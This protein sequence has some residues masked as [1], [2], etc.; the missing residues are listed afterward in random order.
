MNLGQTDPNTQVILQ[1]LIGLVV[2]I[3]LVFIFLKFNASKKNR[4][5]DAKALVTLQEQNHLLSNQIRQRILNNLNTLSDIIGLQPVS[6][7]T[8]HD[9]LSLE[10]RNRTKCLAMIGE[11][12]HLDTKSQGIRMAEFVHQLS[13]HLVQ[14]YSRE[15]VVHI[16]VDTQPIILDVESATHVGLILNE[17][18]SNALQY[19]PVPGEKSKVNIL[20]KERDNKL[21]IR[22]SDNGTGMK[23]PYEPKFSFGLQ[24]VN[25]LVH[26]HRGEM[27]I[28]SRP[29]THVEIALKEFEKATR[30]V[31]VTPTTRVH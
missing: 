30:E 31:F 25:K 29:G 2:L 4:K 13:G 10:G 17:L 28:T 26:K 16:L 8:P 19:G 12:L 23:S 24:L 11:G 14:A 22:V 27:I 20:L 7:G 3:F 6:P 21:V 15:G 18:I 5:E 1:G 9:H